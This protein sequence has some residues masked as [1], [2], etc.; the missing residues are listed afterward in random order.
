MCAV[1]I[2]KFF[3]YTRQHGCIDILHRCND[4]CLEARFG[5]SDICNCLV[6]TELTAC[7]REMSADC[8]EPR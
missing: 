1:T 5:Y 6:M 3:P 2:F 4:P 7:A 8:D